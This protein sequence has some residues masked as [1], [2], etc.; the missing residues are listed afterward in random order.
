MYVR[1]NESENS[2]QYTMTEY[3]LGVDRE[4]CSGVVVGQMALLVVILV[5]FQW[6][7]L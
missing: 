5:C 3:I 2:H 6:M 1:Q 4:C 7:V